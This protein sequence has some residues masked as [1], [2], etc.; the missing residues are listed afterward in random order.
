[1]VKDPIAKFWDNY[2]YLLEA[3]TFATAIDRLLKEI[4]MNLDSASK[5]AKAIDHGK[6]YAVIA[7]CAKED[8]LDELAGILNL[9]L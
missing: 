2:E 3:G 6:S 8:H 4:R 5:T 1:M 7:R 9:A